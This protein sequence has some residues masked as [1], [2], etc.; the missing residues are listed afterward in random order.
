MILDKGSYQVPG[1]GKWTEYQEV[2]VIYEDGT[3]EKMQEKDFE[4]RH[5]K[6]I[7]AEVLSVITDNITKEEALKVRRS[8]NGKELTIGVKYIN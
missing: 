6:N 5:E 1:T 2:E 4:R 8:D 7:R 3:S